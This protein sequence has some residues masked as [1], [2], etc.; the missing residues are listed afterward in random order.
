MTAGWG[1]VEHRL[2]THARGTLDESVRVALEPRDADLRI[3]VVAVAHPIPPPTVTSLPLMQYQLSVG[4]KFPR[5]ERRQPR[6][7]RHLR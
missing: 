4:S 2:G 5:P 6:S 3:W 7:T 1:A